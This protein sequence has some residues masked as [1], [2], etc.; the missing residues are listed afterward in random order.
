MADQKV[1]QNSR[2]L[3]ILKSFTDVEVRS[4][5]KF[6]RENG[7]DSVNA[8]FKFII[9]FGPGYDHPEF[10]SENAH[11][12]LFPKQKFEQNKI[13]RRLNSLLVLFESFI[14]YSTLDGTLEH[15][16]SEADLKV[17]KKE[18]EISD[19]LLLLKF[20]NERGIAG[21]FDK[22]LSQLK[23]SLNSYPYKN[24]FFFENKFKVEFQEADFN[25]KYKERG[26]GDLNFQRS[27]DTFDEYYLFYKFK[28]ICLLVNRYKTLRLKNQYNLGL[29]DSFNT[30]ILDSR[31]S[32]DPGIGDWYKTYQFLISSLNLEDLKEQVIR[33]IDIMEKKDARIIFTFLENAIN[34]DIKDPQEK[35]TALFDLYKI[36]LDKGI[37][38]H[39]KSLH[40]LLFQNIVIVALKLK[41]VTWAD[42]FIDSNLDDVLS[43]SKQEK[44]NLH[45]FTKSLVSFEKKEFE[46]VNQLLESVKFSNWAFKIGRYRL[47]VKSNY[48]LHQI[49]ESNSVWRFRKY[50]FDNKDEIQERI[51]EDHRRFNNFAERIYNSAKGEGEK[52]SRL[53]DE[54]VSNGVPE[55]DWLLEKIGEKE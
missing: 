4:L 55:R 51:I 9:H 26:V 37:I 32:E 45:L 11:R 13:V 31:Y 47:L 20:Y 30:E 42:E 6:V 19:Q 29:L 40:P 8:L 28:L 36:Q 3:A 10:T 1:I 50:L 43:L 53:R 38:K 27:S 54:I 21:R 33:N 18:K 17:S 49:D 25:S 7:S 39:T 12:K 35:Y 23:D 2:A 15:P 34:R 44:K 14:L 41:L 24:Q 16:E 22:I 5:K 48:E 52:L 46:K